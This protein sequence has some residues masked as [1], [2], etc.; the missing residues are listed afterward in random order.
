MDWNAVL[1][2]LAGLGLR[3]GLPLLLTAAAIGLLRWLDGRWR[4]EGEQAVLLPVAAG[5]RCWEVRQ[6]PPEQRARCAAYLN[7]NTPCWQQFRAA[8]GDLKQN[9]LGCG[10][11]VHAPVPVP[12]GRRG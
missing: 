1:P 11:F 3:L 5:P 8:N 4:V 7:P 10:V 6:C 12:A 9:C 2:V